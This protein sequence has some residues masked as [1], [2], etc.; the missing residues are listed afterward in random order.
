MAVAAGN[1]PELPEPNRHDKLVTC[2]V[3]VGK[4][5]ITYEG[6]LT[7]VLVCRECHTEIHIPPGAWAVARPKS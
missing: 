7:N 1:A 5:D 6:R 2:P 4:V 3:C